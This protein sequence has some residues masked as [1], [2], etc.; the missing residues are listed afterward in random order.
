M[1]Q[2]LPAVRDAEI[3]DLPVVESQRGVIPAM[4]LN[5]NP[6]NKGTGDGHE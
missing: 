3:T 6:G 5:G 4:L 2:R 1:K